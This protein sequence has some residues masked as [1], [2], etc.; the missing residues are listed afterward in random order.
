MLQRPAGTEQRLIR[1]DDRP[2]LAAPQLRCGLGEEGQAKSVQRRRQPLTFPNLSG[3]QQR[4]LRALERRRK[5]RDLGLV[6]QQATACHRLRRR[7]LGGGDLARWRHQ[8]FAKRKVDVNRPG[9][10]FGDGPG[11]ESAPHARGVRHLDRDTRIDEPTHGAA[12]EVLLVDRLVGPHPLQLGRTVGGDDDQRCARVRSL[13]HRGMKLRGGGP[14]CGQHQRRFARRLTKS[15]GKK[16][17]AALVDVDDD[18][19][20]RMPLESHRH[21]RRPR[22]R[23][24]ARKLDTVR[25]QLVD[26]GGGEGLGDVSHTIES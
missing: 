8:R 3:H 26:K 6:R 20:P 15:D 10:C 18:L 12:E 23:R 4:T 24:D 17:A 7:G 9:L 13:D 11:G 14:R 22:P 25:C 2:G 1:L 21:R 16:R 19:D 5:R